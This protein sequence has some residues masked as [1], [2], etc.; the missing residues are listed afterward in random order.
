MPPSHPPVGDMGMGV[1]PA[2]A[3][4]DFHEGKPNWQVPAGWQEVS[5]G[6]FLVAKFMLTGEDGATPP[7]MS[8][9][10]P[11]KAAV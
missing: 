6:Q 11:A 5:A 7:S 9:V 1:A 2:A 4:A 8:A 10:P 3:A